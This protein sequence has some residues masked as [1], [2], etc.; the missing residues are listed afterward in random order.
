MGHPHH[1][2]LIAQCRSIDAHP[3]PQLHGKTST[4][5]AQAGTLQAGLQK[6]WATVFDSGVQRQPAEGACGENQ[7]QVN[8]A[9][10]EGNADAK[11]RCSR[12]QR[13][14]TRSNDGRFRQSVVGALG[15]P[16]RPWFATLGAAPIWNRI[17]RLGRECGEIADF[18]S[19][20][21]VFPAP[22]VSPAVRL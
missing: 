18:S 13:T 15:Q 4:G 16:K 9:R 12:S 11:N 17:P 3:M 14:D 22:C 1:L 5:R 7:K 2:V 21:C 10:F 6:V 20:T 8:E 19:A